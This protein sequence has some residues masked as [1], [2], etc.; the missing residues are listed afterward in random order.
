VTPSEIVA[1]VRANYSEAIFGAPTRDGPVDRYSAAGARVACDAIAR[2]LHE[3]DAD[4]VPD[5]ATCGAMIASRDGVIHDMA[6]RLDALAKVAREV[7]GAY[8]SDTPGV[9][10]ALVARARAS[11]RGYA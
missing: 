3:H 2:L 5:R 10:E 7:L 8:E 4:H 11:L 6:A 9:D 1:H